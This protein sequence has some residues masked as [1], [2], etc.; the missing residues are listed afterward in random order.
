[1]RTV[2]SSVVDRFAQLEERVAALESLQKQ[3]GDEVVGMINSLMEDVKELDEQLE[4]AEDNIEHHKTLFERLRLA[5][6][7]S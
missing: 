7:L 4:K 5:D 2:L 6:I 1:M 3:E